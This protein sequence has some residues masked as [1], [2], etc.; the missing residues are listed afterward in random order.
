[1]SELWIFRG[2]QPVIWRIPVNLTLKPRSELRGYRVKDRMERPHLTPAVPLLRCQR[3]ALHKFFSGQRHLECVAGE[4]RF[5]VPRGRPFATETV[6]AEIGATRAA[7]EDPEEYLVW[8]APRPP[9]AKLTPIQKERREWLEDLL[10][11]GVGES[12]EQLAY[13]WKSFCQHIAHTLLNKEKPVDC[14]FFRL[15]NCPLRRGW[16][17][18]IHRYGGGH[19]KR[20]TAVLRTVMGSGNILAF[21]VEGDHALRHIEIEHTA[22]WWKLIRKVEGQ[23]RRK[24]GPEKYAKHF[25]RSLER[26]AL[27]AWHLFCINRA[28]MVQTSARRFSNGRRGGF[29]FVPDKVARTLWS[30]PYKPRHTPD[31]ATRNHLRHAI[32][33][34]QETL[35]GTDGFLSAV[36]YIRPKKEAVRKPAD[37]GV[38]PAVDQPGDG[39]RGSDG[40]LLQPTCQKLVPECE[41]LAPRTG[42][43]GDGVAS[44]T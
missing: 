4:W 13:F 1:M 3:E 44:G 37:E 39:A 23:R 14:Y 28:E 41:V 17:S 20:P 32:K 43:D 18:W 33:A 34:V 31:K 24:L 12:V 21:D 36:S 40:V 5:K 2:T 26:F 35:S 19:P 6:L 27:T 15:H 11:K 10:S 22:E 7:A 9:L 42:I 29:R 25:Q 38:G 30:A 8:G 16:P